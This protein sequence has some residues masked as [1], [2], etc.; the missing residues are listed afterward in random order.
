MTPEYSQ[1]VLGLSSLEISAIASDKPEDLLNE[2]EYLS[3]ESQKEF[4]NFNM[5][6]ELAKLLK[7]ALEQQKLDGGGCD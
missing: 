7:E 6:P 3:M 4:R 5:S 1:F 2:E